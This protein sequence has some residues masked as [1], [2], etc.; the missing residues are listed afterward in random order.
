MA[1]ITYMLRTR[2]IVENPLGY[3]YENISTG[4]S[5]E[6]V[7]ALASFASSAQFSTSNPRTVEVH[8]VDP[9]NSADSY[10]AWVYKAGRIS[11]TVGDD[12]SR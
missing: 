6:W 10:L 9:T 11:W 7:N 1:T 5:M 3:E 4:V 8:R 12:G 2:K